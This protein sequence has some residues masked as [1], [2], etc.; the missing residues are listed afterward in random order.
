VILFITIQVIDVVRA[1]L[2]QTPI[3]KLELSPFIADVM[4]LSP[5]WLV[6]GILLCRRKAL[7]YVAGAGLLLLGSMLFVGLGFVVMFPAIYA[8][9]PIDVA[10]VVLMLVMGL[11]C[12]VPFVL[13]V[14]GAASERDPSSS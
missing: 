9:S 8:G 11:I 2:S 4:V 7:G 10:G 12:F 13:F 1:I 6:G 14:R 3:D 5:M